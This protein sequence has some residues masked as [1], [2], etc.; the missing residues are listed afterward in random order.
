MRQPIAGYLTSAAGSRLAVTVLDT[1]VVGNLHRIGFEPASPSRLNLNAGGKLQQ[2]AVLF[3]QLRELGIGF[4]AGKDWSPAD[5]FE[6]LR[7]AGLI[8]G[9]YLR[10]AWTCDDHYVVTEA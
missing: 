3:R 8:E 6:H 2:K 5:V 1:N 7:D 10:V 4:A 9:S